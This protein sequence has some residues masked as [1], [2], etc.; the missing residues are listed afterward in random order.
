MD[1]DHNESFFPSE[2][3]NIGSMSTWDAELSV[4]Q[5]EDDLALDIDCSNQPTAQ[6]VNEWIG[7]PSDRASPVGPQHF[8][9]F[10][11][12]RFAISGSPFTRSDTLSGSHTRDA[13]M[14]LDLGNS[15]IQYRAL[16]ITS[17]VVDDDPS[18][19]VWDGVVR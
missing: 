17:G 5:P 19:W 8:S 12:K 4:M 3:Y 9:L 11:P 15:S 1:I 6:V 13:S 14:D 18:T 2:R 16:E 7:Q 10:Q